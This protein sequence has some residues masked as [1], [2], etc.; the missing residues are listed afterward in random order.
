M[1]GQNDPLDLTGEVVSH[2]VDK[3]MADYRIQQDRATGIA[4]NSIEKHSKF[5]Q[6]LA[7]GT[8][9]QEILRSRLF[10]DVN[11][12]ARR[13]MYYELRQYTM[14]GCNQ[15]KLTA[16]LGQLPPDT[17][18]EDHYELRREL[19]LTHTSTCERMPH[20][21]E[22][23]RNLFEFL[24][25]PVSILDIGCGLHPLLFPFEKNANLCCYTALDK[26]Q[27][28][29]ST[30]SA[31]AGFV[32][33][34]NEIFYPLNWKIKDHWNLIREVTG[35][36]TFDVAFLMKLIPVVARQQRHLLE[37]LKGTPAKL[38]VITGSRLSMTKYVNIEGRER[39]LV[40]N[41]IEASGKK[42]IGEFSIRDEFCRIV[43]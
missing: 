6:L 36:S 35:I 12:N 16:S 7:S 25:S 10:A 31:F 39:K 32:N 1:S 40:N 33:Q 2:I 8:P 43:V 14:P 37:V 17:P 30:L 27:C 9:L 3:A 22:F 21:R 13:K 4:L 42:L 38:W 15:E 19:S 29:I 34:D 18:F 41:F 11:R 26:D 5:R 24:E 20:L 23:Y 28:C